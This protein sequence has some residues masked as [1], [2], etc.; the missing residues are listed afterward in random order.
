M[1]KTLWAGFLPRACARW[2]LG[3][4]ALC[5]LPAA[6]AHGDGAYWHD[7]G[8][9]GL[10]PQWMLT[11]PSTK[12]LD[13]LSLPGTHDSGTFPGNSGPWATT[14]T[15][16]IREQL[17]SGIRWLDIRLRHYDPVALKNCNDTHTSPNC[18]LAVFHGDFRQA[19]DVELEIFSPVVTFLRDHPSE[20]VIMR[21]ARETAGCNCNPAYPL[22]DLLEQPAVLNGVRTS[23]KYADYLVR[24]GCPDP[25]R[26]ALGRVRPQGAAPDPLSC[27]ARGKLLIIDQYMQSRI[28]AKHHYRRQAD[29]E[30]A[31][32]EVA[33]LDLITMWDLHDKLW[34]PAK[35]HL[36]YANAVPTPPKRLFL[37][38][39]TDSFPATPWFWASGHVDDGT[40]SA[41]AST[42][43]IENRQTGHNVDTWPDFPRTACTDILCTI[44]FEGMNTLAANHLARPEFRRGNS[45][46]GIVSADF[47]GNRLITAV[48]SLN[49][50]ATFNRPTFNYTLKTSNGRPYQPGSWTNEPVVVTPICSVFCSGDR[51]AVTEDQPD[52]FT[53]TVTGGGHTVAIEATPVRLDLV[54]PTITAAALTPPGASGW[55]T[56]NVTVRYSCAD[57][58][59]SGLVGCPADQV[60]TQQR[61]ASSDVQYAFDT[62]G[63]KSNPSNVVTVRID[64]TPPAVRYVGNLGSYAPGQVVDIRCEAI[65]RESGVAQSNCADIRGLASSFGAGTH[66]FSASATDVAGL[67][68]AATT[69]F[70]VVALPGDVSA[71]GAIDCRDIALVKATFGKR[72]GTAG[73][74]ARA[75]TNGDAVIDIRDLSFVAQKLA[76]GTT[77]P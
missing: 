52:G 28:G 48:A 62:A 66:R 55:Y 30:F 41:R 45:R 26:L 9:A 38:G 53:Y 57:S 16:T 42:G 11:L 76:A 5:A 37:T 75:D 49:P 65:D 47:P 24:G 44:S 10:N 56:G 46:V 77:C 74:D 18:R 73:Y 21:I 36:S 29:G 71:D 67:A 25:D 63:N 59:G 35:A 39:L 17:V 13:Q 12:T 8:P 1:P 61:T 72:A 40:N 33:N 43:A 14:Q 15:M 20:T 7:K 58:G 60:L 3:A 19:V 69:S 27:D 2:A 32:L 51:A 22:V 68:A 50:G 54:R 23:S 70:T 34:L 6:L 4:A 31:Y 64:K